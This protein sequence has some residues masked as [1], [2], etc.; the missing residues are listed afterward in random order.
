M[1]INLSKKEIEVILEWMDIATGYLASHTFPN[2]IED[3]VTRTSK[4]GKDQLF[5]NGSRGIAK[6]IEPKVKLNKL[7][8]KLRKAIGQEER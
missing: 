7:E 4:A 8:E 2:K 5:I 1:K 3:C 6:K